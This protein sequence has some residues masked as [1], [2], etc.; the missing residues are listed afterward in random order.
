MDAFNRKLV[1]YETVFAAADDRERFVPIAITAHGVFAEQSL[2]WLH[3]FS[4]VCAAARG[5]SASY[6]FDAL[7]Q[8]LSVALWRGNSRM[9]RSGQL[10]LDIND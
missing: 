9:L 4:N 5:V 1:K 10:P 6:E 2:R 8:R 3:A 7:M